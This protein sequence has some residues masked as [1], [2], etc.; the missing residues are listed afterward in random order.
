MRVEVKLLGPFEFFVDGVSAVPTATKP[1]QLL[2]M[3]AIN[4]GNVVSFS[5]L[6]EETWDHHPPRSAVS[7]LHTYILHLR[8]RLRKIYENTGSGSAESVIVTKRNGYLLDVEPDEVDVVTYDRLATMGRRAVNEGDDLTAAAILDRAL[9]LWHGN[10]LVDIPTGPLL[11]IE[12][13][14]LAENRLSDLDLRIDAELRLGRHHQLLGELSA[15]CARHPILENF[16][17][18]YML[19]LY[20]SGRHLRALQVFRDLHRNMVDQLGIEPSPRLR[21]LHRLILSGD[22]L[23]DDPRFVSSCWVPPQRLVERNQA[24]PSLAAVPE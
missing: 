19:A 2:A 18:Q 5:S 3:L 21:E 1:C 10:A 17:A 6:I 4:A 11:A 16:S 14:R 24:A 12:A 22:P 20:R 13:T 23:A 15:L 8:R 7:T 9:D